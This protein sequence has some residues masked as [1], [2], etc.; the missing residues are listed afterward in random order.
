VTEAEYLFTVPSLALRMMLRESGRRASWLARQ[1]HVSAA[2]VS[3]W[4]DGSRPM[5]FVTLRK[6]GKLLHYHVGITVTPTDS[7]SRTG[8]GGG[9]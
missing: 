4:Q 3:R 5:S 7:G 1:L 8:Q 6:I 9:K 2:A